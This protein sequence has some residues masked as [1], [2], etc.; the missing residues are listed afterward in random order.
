MKNGL[1]VP[2]A[3]ITTLPSSRYCSAFGRTYGS[4]TCSIAIADITRAVDALLAHRVGQRER[5][6]HGGQHAH[7]VGG[8]AVHADR[9]AGDAAEDVAAADHDGDFAAE[10]RHLLHLAHHADDRRAI[11]AERVVTHQGFTGKLEQ[12]ALVGGH[13]FRLRLRYVL[14][15]SAGA[16]ADSRYRGGRGC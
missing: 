1:P 7:V 2:A 4:T 3:K 8:G 16:S 13:G 11:D 6:H 15:R 5:V 14:M 9:A 10:L 12:D